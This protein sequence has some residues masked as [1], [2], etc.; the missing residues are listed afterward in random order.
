MRRAVIVSTPA[1][2]ER[3]RI[4]GNA[5]NT[6]AEIEQLF[7]DCAYW[8]EHV[9]KPDEAP[10][11]CDPDGTLRRLADGLD[12]MLADDTGSGQI[13]PIGGWMNPVFGKSSA[14]KQ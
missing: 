3:A 4:V 2:K 6:R 13:P 14:K 8:N 7:T 10:I 9:R 5:R 1:T 11:D 12:R